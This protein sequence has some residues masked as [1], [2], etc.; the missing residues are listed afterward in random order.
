MFV[1]EGPGYEEDHR[2]EPFVGKAG[3]LLERILA[4]IGLSRE[5]VYITNVVKC[6]P[7][8]DPR[9]PEARGNDRP[10][11]PEEIAAC[12]PFLEEQIRLVCP[13]VIVTLGAVPA[14]ALLGEAEPLARLR[15]RWGIYRGGAAPVKVLPTFH[16]AALLRKPELKRE[17]W[18]DMKALRRELEAG[19]DDSPPPGGASA[20][21]TRAGA[22]IER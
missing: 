9:S 22:A 1:G 4:S 16:P 3:Q 10:P 11:S 13:Q 8:R 17:V 18:A 12:R 15:G 5:G 6:H 7:M 14:R 20:S 19:R 2:G 21:G